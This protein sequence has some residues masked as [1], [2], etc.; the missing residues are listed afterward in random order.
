MTAHPSITTRT[1]GK[2]SADT[3][4][5]ADAEGSGRDAR[6]CTLEMAFPKARD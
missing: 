6:H 3:H 4:T 2:F 1:A 5:L